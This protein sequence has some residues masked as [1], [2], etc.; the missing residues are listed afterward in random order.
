MD[1][2]LPTL[3]EH[4]LTLLKLPKPWKITDIVLAEEELRVDITHRVARGPAG[5]LSG[6]REKKPRQGPREDAH[7]AS[8]GCDAHA[9]LLALCGAALELHRA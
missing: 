8:S 7:L 9:D 1:R 2:I 6:M 3:R 5:S 4:C